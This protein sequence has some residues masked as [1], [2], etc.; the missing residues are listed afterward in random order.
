MQTVV[1]LISVDDFSNGRK[2]AENI[3]NTLFNTPDDILRKVRKGEDGFVAIYPITD[4]MDACNNQ[5]IELEGV[6]VSYAQVVKMQN[7]PTF[8]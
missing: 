3:E 5:E 7:I 6:W 4:F 1:I 2:I 8:S